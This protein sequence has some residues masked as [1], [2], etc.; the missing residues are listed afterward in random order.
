MQTDFNYYQRF[1]ATVAMWTRRSLWNWK[2]T[3]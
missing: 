1:F 3:D 2:K